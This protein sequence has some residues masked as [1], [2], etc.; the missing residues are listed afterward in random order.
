MAVIIDAG[1]WNDLHPTDKKTVGERLALAARAVA[2][3][4]A[5][6]VYSGP[7]LQSVRSKG[8]ELVLEFDAMGSSLAV[9]GD[10]LLGFAIAGADG[11]YAWASARIEEGRVLLHSPDVPKPEFVRYAW[12][13]NPDTANLYN[14][15][16][17]PASPFEARAGVAVGGRN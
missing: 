13:D 14:A 16:G 12:A 2:Y 7:V 5:D 1:E 9:H 6:I 3:G 15:G 17:L 4:D 8:N 10:E 11:R